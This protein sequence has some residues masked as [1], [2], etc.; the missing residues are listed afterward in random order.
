MGDRAILRRFRRSGPSLC[1]HTHLRPTL[2]APNGRVPAQ[3]DCTPPWTL[4][5]VE[6]APATSPARGFLLRLPR[7]A[8]LAWRRILLRPLRRQR[9]PPSLA[10]RTSVPARSHSI[11]GS[12]SPGRATR[13][14]IQIGK[15]TLPEHGAVASQTGDGDRERLLQTSKTGEGRA[16]VRSAEFEPGDGGI[17][18]IPADDLPGEGVGLGRPGDSQLITS[19]PNNAEGI[20]TRAGGTAPG[21]AGSASMPGTAG[22]WLTAHADASDPS[23]DPSPREP[24]RRLEQRGPQGCAP[25]ARPEPSPSA[26]AQRSCSRDRPPE[27]A[28]FQAKPV[29]APTGRVRDRVVVEPESDPR[30]RR[31]RSVARQRVAPSPSRG[32]RAPDRSPPAAGRSGLER[33][34]VDGDNRRAFAG[35]RPFGWWRFRNPG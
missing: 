11:G 1:T 24:V 2:P 33:D 6:P 35:D 23:D 9:L 8:R 12:L 28:G 26:C 25:P 21:G 22:C 32:A 14:Q 7:L 3:T 13:P 19:R 34:V 30:A 18:A 16:P 5:S 27:W 15:P 10:V 29:S 20:A 4:R 17:A 31:E